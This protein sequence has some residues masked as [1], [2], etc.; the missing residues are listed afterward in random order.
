[1][2]H[3]KLY[4]LPYVEGV[5]V[6]YIYLL[7][8]Y[9]IAEIKE[10]YTKSVVSFS[11]YGDLANK[12]NSAFSP[13]ANSKKKSVISAD[14]VSR[15]L[16]NE[17]YKPFFEIVKKDKCN[18]LVLN[19]YF[20]G[21]KGKPFIRLIPPI[22]TLLTE[23]QDNLLAKYVVYLIHACGTTNN[24]A[25]FTAKQFLSANGYSLKANNYQSKLCEYNKLLQ[26]RGIIT[27]TK[28]KDDRQLERN[29]YSLRDDD[30]TN[31]LKTVLCE[32]PN[33]DLP[34]CGFVF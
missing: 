1:M 5:E 11:S 15:V 23:Q 6:N 28:W 33:R 16:K 24:K 2:K 14:T 9:G 34:Q 8:L 31:T 27:I 22:Y 20:K 12:I 29:T 21:V 18:Y 7:Y 25:D 19:N 17:S 10:G 30:Y 3:Y 4:Y 26:E 13:P 32:S